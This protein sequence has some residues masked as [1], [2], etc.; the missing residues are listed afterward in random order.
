MAHPS[1]LPT[2]AR[3]LREDGR[4]SLPLASAIASAFCVLSSFRQLHHNISE[5]QVG[6]TVLE[7]VQLEV[8]RTAQRITQQ[9]PIA[10]PMAL[11]TRLAAVAPGQAPPLS[12]G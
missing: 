12:D 7:L 5:L 4:R 2:L 8:Q 9:G 6:A 10:A 1:L 11:V 3:L